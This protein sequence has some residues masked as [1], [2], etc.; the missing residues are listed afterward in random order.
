MKSGKF[1]SSITEL[2]VVFFFIS[3][4]LSAQTTLVKG[5][6]ADVT[7]KPSKYGLVGIVPEVYKYASFF[8]G[9]DADGNFSIKLTKPGLNYL[10]FS[11]PGHNAL[12]IPIMNLTDQELDIDINLSTYGYK[13]SFDK[14]GIAGTFN[15]FNI[16]APVPMIKLSDGTYQYEF[17]TD[18]KEIKYQLCGI[19]KFNRTINAP[20]CDSFEPDSSGDYR[21]IIHVE[22]NKAKIIFNPKDLI[23][24]DKKYSIKIDGNESFKKIVD[25]YIEYQEI[26][27]DANQRIREYADL[28]KSA[29]NFHYDS[30]DYL[31]NILGKV[32][33]ETDQLLK[34]YLK[35][36]YFSL[37]AYKP[38]NYNY[39]KASLFFESITPDNPVWEFSPNSFSAYYTLLPQ[40]KWNSFVDQFFAKTKST[41]IKISIL[42]NKLANAKFTNNTDE[43][44]K[45]HAIITNEMAD[46]KDAVNL[47]KQFPIDS[48]IKIGADIP[49]FETVSIDDPS[50]KFSKQSML[51]KIYLID[52]WATWCAP[53]VGE[54]A[55]LHNTYEK[56]KGKGLEIISLSLDAKSDDVEKFRSDKWKMPWKN[57]FINTKEGRKISESFEVIGIPKPILVSA[58]GKILEMNEELRGDKLEKTL[59]KYFK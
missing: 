8:S 37:A 45:L 21:S 41:P 17:D 35:L 26:S 16:Q 34:D 2:L 46:V 20:I 49:D 52:F 6:L 36:I 4:N 25:T 30:G 50:Q 12:Q 27:S 13:D 47:L 31:N 14:L 48:K 56:F 40:F 19:E 18:L 53:C 32:E 28:N 24:S 3:I 59:A 9:C 10:M 58:D 38:E 57:S 54:M 23:R 1:I 15:D 5:R 43:L 7:D 44:R 51:G 39:E 55:T 29:T 42:Q 33:T 22:N 11:I